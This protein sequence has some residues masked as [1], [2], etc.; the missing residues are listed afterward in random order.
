MGSN[1]KDKKVKK[2]SKKD[3]QMEDITEE[4]PVKAVE[5]AKE[6]KSQLQRLS[7]KD[8]EFFNFL[9]EHDKELL[10]F[11]EEEEDEDGQEDDPMDQSDGLAKKEEIKTITSEMV[12]TWIKAIQKEKKIG[13]IRSIMRAFRHACHCG[14]EDNESKLSSMSFPVFNKILSF[15]LSEADGIF[16]TIFK[17]PLS[18]GKKEMILELM[19]TRAWKNY[20]H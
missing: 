8:P 11:D 20:S 17:L 15:V 4:V 13:A 6:H 5:N 3:E 7:E 16:R 19:N 14:D 9:K 18:G 1:K 2:G 12:D 10:E